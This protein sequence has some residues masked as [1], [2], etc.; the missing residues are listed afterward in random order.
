MKTSNVLGLALAFAAGGCAAS[1]EP[2]GTAS[3]DDAA[4]SEGALTE[5]QDAS[6]SVDHELA[7]GRSDADASCPSHPPPAAS[8]GGLMDRGCPKGSFCSFPPEAL[9]GSADAPGTCAV[10][11]QVCYELY[12][13]VCGCDDHTYGNTCFA[14]LSGVSVSHDG[15]C[16]PPVASEGDSCGGFRTSPS[17]VCAEG[18]YCNY[19]IGDTCGWADAPGTCAKKSK[20]CGK[21]Y[22]PVCGCN[23]TTYSNACTASAAGISVLHKGGCE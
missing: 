7:P 4:E 9:C 1:S 3:P 19:A 23:G 16:E 22:A 2:P 8:C 18:L 13:P 17:P 6:T 21:N 20:G 14:V 12:K 10:K 15:R 11:P 5:A